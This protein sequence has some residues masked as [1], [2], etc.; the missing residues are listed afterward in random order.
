MGPARATRARDRWFSGD[1]LRRR[2]SRGD[3]PTF[4]GPRVVPEGELAGRR[5]RLGCSGHDAAAGDGRNSP[6]GAEATGRVAARRPRGRRRGGGGGA[7][8]R[9]GAPL[10][11]DAAPFVKRAHLCRNE[12]T[13]RR[14]RGGQRDG[15]AA[16]FDFYTGANRRVRAVAGKSCAADDHS[17]HVARVVVLRVAASS[18]VPSIRRSRRWHDAGSTPPYVIDATQGSRA[19]PSDSSPS[20]SPCRRWRSRR[21]GRATS[22][23]ASTRSASSSNS[24]SS[25]CP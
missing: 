9:P 3:L 7:A 19:C 2:A 13:L 24:R 4:V 16:N 15:S 17:T 22:W 11:P 5:G 1:V 20:A 6:R 21:S 18:E 10:A 12:Q 14:W 23:S 25:C 8:R